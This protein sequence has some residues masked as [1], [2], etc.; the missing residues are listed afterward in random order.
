[1]DAS[2]SPV[3]KLR[4]K[5]RSVAKAAA[6]RPPPRPLPFPLARLGTVLL[7]AGT[8]YVISLVVARVIG[9]ALT[10][11]VMQATHA[12]HFWAVGLVCAAFFAGHSC[13]IGMLDALMQGRLSLPP[14]AALP[15]PA[16]SARNPWM[17]ALLNGCAWGLPAAAISCWLAGRAWPNGVP[18][19]SFAYQFAAAAAL[20]SA[21]VVLVH[22]GTP[23]LKQAQLERERRR[24]AGTHTAYLW[25]RQIL[26]QGLVNGTINA[27]VGAAIV[28]GTL[29]DPNASVPAALLQHD[30]VA[31]AI[32]LAFA[33]VG[34]AFG[35]ARF[36]RRWNVVPELPSTISRSTRVA[37]LLA[38]IAFAA[39]MGLLPR[40]S[41]H[42]AVNARTFVAVR[43]LACTIYSALLAYWMA[44]WALSTRD[45][46]P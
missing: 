29:H 13:S 4:D 44:S 35:H 38:F 32:G 26:P 15:P 11:D 31:T 46:A 37:V 5:L 42:E 18:V 24:F 3:E 20:L 19:I 41:G 12:C 45:G 7:I 22:T 36:D 17:V 40:L 2:R 25:Q 39:A 27:W 10:P 16:T 23:F 8:F 34:G 30:A 1:L 33:V 43:T 28:P 6:S 14:T 21:L 9:R